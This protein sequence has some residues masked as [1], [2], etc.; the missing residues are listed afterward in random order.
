[1]YLPVRVS[2]SA[3][4]LCA[5]AESFFDILADLVLRN[6][7]S[8]HSG[9][10][11]IDIAAHSSFQGENAEIRFITP[12]SDLFNSIWLHQLKSTRATKLLKS[13]LKN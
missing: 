1:M 4:R 7:P 11:T 6:H 10:Q 3:W 2:I 8:V 5:K 13:I 9:G 12:R